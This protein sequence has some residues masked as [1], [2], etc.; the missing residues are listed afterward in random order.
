ME[1]PADEA[2]LILVDAADRVLG[3]LDR[4]RCHDGDGI[5]H[6]AFSVLVFDSEERLLVQRRSASKRLWPHYWSNTCCSHPRRGQDTLVAAT[7]RLRHELGL[8][9]PLQF[10]Y[11]FEY[12]ARFADA[13]SEHE[14][15]SVFAGRAATGVSVQA[16]PEEVSAHCW[17][18]PTEVDAWF[19]DRERRLTP[20]FAQEWQRI[21]TQHREWV[22]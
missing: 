2:P 11:Q 3:Y 21:R 15:C 8:D 20:W 12:R 4:D 13:G 16:N 5:L 10:L 22:R 7:E 18:L 17:L 14:L 9:V 1:T 19:L 6:R